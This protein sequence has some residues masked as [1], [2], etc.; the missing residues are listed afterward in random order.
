[1][2]DGDNR[3][4]PGQALNLHTTLFQNREQDRGGREKFLSMAL[5]KGG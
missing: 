1:M 2:P 5:E 3:V 4:I